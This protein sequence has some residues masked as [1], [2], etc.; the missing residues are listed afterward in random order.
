M[1]DRSRS[2]APIT[3]DESARLA[4]IAAPDSEAMLSLST[5]T[6]SA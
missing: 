2:C 6:K 4:S 3:V 1:N 5:A